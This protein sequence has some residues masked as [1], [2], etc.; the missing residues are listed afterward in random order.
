MVGRD[1]LPKV[2]RF[3]DELEASVL[4]ISDLGA[5]SSG[6]VSIAAVPTAVF[7][8][9]PQA[10]ARFSKKYPRIRIR[11]LDIGANEG[12]EAV[13]RGEVDFGINFLGASHSDIEFTRLVDD[14]FMLACRHDHALAS[15]KR[16]T[17]QNSAPSAWSPLDEI[18]ATAQSSTM[19]SPCTASSSPGP[20][21]LPTFPA[22]L[23]R[24]RPD[25]AS[26]CYRASRL[27]HLDI[28]S[29][30]ESGSP[31]RRFRGR[32]AS[33]GDGVQACRPPRTN[34]STCFW[35][36]GGPAGNLLVG[37]YWPRGLNRGVQECDAVSRATASSISRSSSPAATA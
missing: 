2:R 22:R 13:A 17:G 18:A 36:R 20:T 21:R 35:R 8:F 23:A 37:C 1:F 12:L 11:I 14:P 7:H 6:L 25:L 15:R 3:L 16:V 26:P 19:R 32:S 34:C 29:Y 27:P 28:R 33:F 31:P 24:S 30:E 10:I 4:G 5:R 9:L